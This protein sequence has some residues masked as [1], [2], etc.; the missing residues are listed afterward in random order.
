MSTNS[1]DP[2]HVTY[3]NEFGVS[4][5][6]ALQQP[7]LPPVAE[8]A[9]PPEII[10]RKRSL[11][12]RELVKASQDAR[13][14]ETEIPPELLSKIKV[15]PPVPKR[16]TYHS[17]TIDEPWMRLENARNYSPGASI[18]AEVGA[19]AG[20]TKLAKKHHSHEALNNHDK[21]PVKLTCTAFRDR[22]IEF[23]IEQQNSK[24]ALDEDD[25]ASIMLV[26]L[27]KEFVPDPRTYRILQRLIADEATDLEDECI[28]EAFYDYFGSSVKAVTV[29]DLEQS[30]VNNILRAIPRNLKTSY[31]AQISHLLEEV[32]E[33]FRE[34]GK[35][36][37]VHHIL[38]KPAHL[39]QQQ[40]L[41]TYQKQP[42]FSETL[43]NPS[44]WHK[45]FVEN[46][47]KIERLL[48]I[49]NHAL[50]HLMQT[51][52][53][54]SHLRYVDI[55]EMR[56]QRDAFR[57]S[58]Y[59]SLMLVQAEKCRTKIWHGWLAI[60]LKNFAET[61]IRKRKREVLPQK[62][63]E[64]FF[65][66]AQMLICNQLQAIMVESI[67]D[68]VH[69]F[70][71]YPIA[72]SNSD[73]VYVKGKNLK[74]PR[75]SVRLT[76]TIKAR[77]IE[78]D[79]PFNEIEDAV[80]DGLGFLVSTV[81]TAPRIE[82]AIY[83]HNGEALLAM[84]F[85][86]IQTVL[87]NTHATSV[88]SDG[89]PAFRMSIGDVE[90]IKLYVE[91]SLIEAT[92]SHLKKYVNN[93]FAIAAEY[94]TRYDPYIELFSS[95]I[96]CQVEEFFSTAHS[97]EE[98][99]EQIEKYKSIVNEIL[100]HPRRVELVLIDL[101]TE[102]LHRIFVAR[103]NSLA[104]RFIT[105]ITEQ[106][107][108]HQ[109]QIC[110]RYEA[111]E[112]R[113][114]QIPEGFKEM[115]EQM[116]YM[117]KTLEDEL[118]LLL[119]ELEESRR[120][121]MHIFN[122]SL[123][124]DEHIKLNS[125][126]FTWPAKIIPILEQHN[127]IIGAAREKSEENLRERRTKFEL[128]L[129]EIRVQVDELKEV[130]DL[131]EMPFYVKKVQALA[132]QLQ[133]AQDS[134]AGFNKEEQLF[135][136]PETSYPQRKQIM[137][138]LEPFQALYT[139]AVTFQKSYKKWM[140]G[141]LLEL[142]AEQIE[143]E[144]DSLK[145]DM[146][147]V[148]GALVQDSAP[149][150]IAKAVKE[151]IDE[152]MVNIPLIH[153]LCNPGM[154]DRHW[155]KMSAAAEFEIRPDGS[156]SLRKMLKM[157]LEQFLVPFQ[158][159]SDFASKEYT[160]EK[161]M[162]KMFQE[163]EPLEFILIAYR[164]T[165]THI[166][167][168][169]DE[170]QQLLDDQ[171]VKTQSMRGSP[172]I[173]PFEQ[174]IKEWEHKLLTTQEIIDEWLKVQA[175]WLYLEPIFSSEDIMNQMP[176]ESKKFKM[177][178]YSWRKTMCVVSQDRH[179]LKIT[180]IPN[181]LE[182]LQKNNIML[183]EIL[184]GLNSYLEVK[185]LFFPRFF[186][187]SN[188]EMLEILSE[189]KDPTRVQPHLK[190]CF[191]G[192]ATLEFD[193]KLDIIS[194]YS[195][196]KE[197]LALTKKVSTVDAKGTV[198]KWLR[199]VENAMLSSLHSIIKAAY[200]AY[201]NSPRE[202]WVLEWPGQ[203][204]ICVSQIYWTL[205]V[206][207]AI[208]EG[209]RGIEQHLMQLNR[210][211]NETIKLV[212]GELS[213]MARYTL[214][215]LVVIDVHAR[216][217]IANMAHTEN[218]K[219]TNDFA[220]L[221]QLRYYW[222]NN[223]VMVKM[224]NAQKRYGYEYL[225]NSA[226]LVIT[227]LTDR[228][229]RTLFGALHLNLGGAPEGP[230]GTGKTETTKD[231]AKALAKQCVVFNCSDGL[232]YLAM[233]K[234][235]KGLATSGAWACFDEFNRIDLEVLSVVAQQILTIQRAIALDLKE[236]MFEGSKLALNQQCAVF[237][238]MNPG[239]AGRSEL[240][241]NLKALFRTVAMMVPDYSLIAEI[242]LYSFGFI[243]AR[244]LARKIAAT[245]RLC[246]E[247]LSSQDHYDYGMRAVKSVLTA[248]G[249]LKLKY[250]D[251][252][253]SVLVL[254]SIID[255][256]LPKFLSQD[257][258][259]FKGIATDLF[260]GVC[261]PKSDYVK[262]EDAIQIACQ[263]M[264]LQ[265]VPA[266]V[267]KVFQ[268]YEMMLV[269][270]GY[271]LVGEPFS[272]KTTAYRVLGEAL[273]IIAANEPAGTDE[274][275]SV[276]YKAI[277]PKS[278]TMGQLYGQFDPISHEWTD[279]VLATSFRSYASSTSPDRK[280]VIFDGPVDAIWVENMNTVLDDNKKLC[281]M[282]GEIIQL[283]NT[284]SL[285]FEV[286]DL[287][288]ASPAT[289]SRCG[290]VYLEPERLGWRPLLQSWL[291]SIT[292]LSATIKEYISQ[293]F[294]TF[295]QP[296]LTFVRKDCK[297]L[298][299]TTDIGLVNSLLRLFDSTF[300][301][302]RKRDII[303]ENDQDPLWE[304][305]IQ[306]RFLFCMAWT[307]G[308][309]IDTPSQLK[310]DHMMRQ[311]IYKMQPPLK[312]ELPIEGTIYD[313][314]YQS[315]QKESDSDFSNS[316]KQ[317]QHNKDAWIPWLQTI[318]A[319]H[320]P[321]NSDFN[322]II[323]PTKDTAR[324]NY[325][326]DLMILH[327]IPLLLVGPTGTG[328]SKYI[329][330]KLL[331]GI[332][333]DMFLPLAINFSAR[334]SA[335][336]VQDLVMAK[337][338]KRRK[339]VFGAPV[340]KRYIVFID[341]L[342]MPAKE[343]YGAQPPIELFRQWIDH[344]NWYDRKD[345]SRIELVDIQL[346]AAMGPPGGGRN[347]ITPRF[348]RHFNQVV[349]NSF[350][351]ATM[352]RIFNSILE[353]HFSRFEFV[354][355]IRNISYILVD[356][357]MSVYQ[358][359]VKNLLPTPAKTHYTFNLRDFAKVIQGL[360]LSRPTHFGSDTS[361]L[362]LWTHEVY[363]VYYDRLVADEDRS[364]MFAFVM[365]T[366]NEKFKK[367]PNIVF[368]HVATGDKIDESPTVVDD[369]MR[370]VFFGD[371]V[372]CASPGAETNYIEVEN[373]DTIS[374]ICKAQLAEYNQ[375]K[376]TKLDLVLFRFAIEHVSKIC[377]ILKLPGGNALLVGV[378]GS[379]RQSLTR[380][381]AFISKYQVFQI[382]ISKSYSRVEWRDDLKKILTMTGVENQKTVFLF[383][384]T[385]IREESFIEDVNSLLNAGDV[386]N[387]FAADERQAIVEKLAN[388]A[389]E[390][391]KAADASPMAIYSYFV[392][393]VKKNLH[394]VL[395]MS[396]I[397]DA[398]RA[399]LRQFSSIVN[400]CTIDWFQA[401]PND[402]L[403]AVA[404]QF[405]Q[406][407]NLDT[408]IFDKVIAMC[409]YF[410]QYAIA[411]SQR[412][413]V[414]L[415]R[416]NYVTPTSYLELLNAYKTL[417][418][419]KFQEISMVR[420]RY[421]GGLDKLQFAAEQI[422]RMQVDLKELQPQLL[423]TS[424]ETIEMLAKIEKESVEVEST[425]KTVAS[426]EAIASFKAE[427]SAAMKNECE[428][429]LAEALPLLN[430]ALAAL[431]TLK[432]TDIDLVKSMKNPPDGVKLVME[433]V[434]VMKDIKPEKIPDPSGS[435]RMVL[436]YWKP[437]LKMLGDPQFLNSLKS[438]DKDDIPPHVIKKIRQTFIPNPEFKP[439]KVRNASSAAEGLCSWIGAMEAY[440]RVA[441]IVAPKQEALAKAEAELA[442]TMKGLDEKRALLKEIMDR[443]QSLNNNLQA[444]TEK[445]A[446]LEKEVKS[447]EDQL[448]RAQKLLGGL[449]GE[450]H[451]WTE[452]TKQLDGTL[453]NL[454]G[455]VLIS[456]G[457]AAY[458]GA[459][460][461]L[462]RQECVASWVE[463]LKKEKIPCTDA[464]SLIKV[465][466]D[467]IKIREW[468]IAGLP[469][470]AFSVDNGIIVQNARRWPLM[471][472][473]QGQAN[474]WVK[475]MEKNHKLVIIKL[476]DT[477]FVRNLE[478]AI[479]FGLPV[480]LENL[481]EELDPILD[482][483]L[484]KQTFKSGGATCIRLGD[485]VIEYAES[486]RLY[487]TTKLRNPHYFPET[488]VKVSLLNFMITPE[489]LEDQL[490]GIVV[491]K[492]RPEL[493]EEK[494]QL[495]FQ[496]AENK[497]KLQ[498]I[499]DQ[500]LQILSSAEGNILENETAI[501]VLSSSKVLSVE[502]FDK[503]R[504][505]EETECKI[506][507]TRE[508]YR[509]IAN[510]SA[511]NKS[512]V[513]KRRLKNLESYFTYSLYCNVCRSLFEK[514]KLL[515]SFLLCITILRKYN[516]LDEAEFAHFMT[517]GIGLGGQCIPNPDPS[518]IS[519]KGWTEIGR[520]SDLPA[521]KGLIQEF[522]LS[523][524]KQVIDTNDLLEVKFPGK[525][526]TINDF[527]HL[528]I[529][530][531][532]RPEKIVPSVQEFV[533]AKLGHKFIEPPIFDLAGSYEDSSNHSP[534]IFI[535]SPGV[536]PM[537]QLIKFAEDQGFGGQKCQ[538]IS[539]GQGQGPIAA[540]MIREAQKGG[541]WVVLQNCHLAVS[542][543]STLEKIVDDMTSG[544][545]V[546]RDFRLWLTSY[547]SPKFPSSILQ[548]G[549]KMTNEP[550]KGIKANI[551]KSYLSDP[552]SN[553]K[554]FAA[555]KKP[556]EWEK[557]LFGLCTFHAIVQ[558]RRNFG[559]LGWNI[560]YEFNESDLRISIRQLQMFLDEYAEIPFKAII[561]L[562]GECNYG[563]RV[564]DE[565]D[566]R[567]LTNL[568]TT[569]Y[570]PAIVEDNGYR[571]SPSGVYY[572]PAKGKYDQYLEYV[573][574]L[575]LN[576]SPE[577]F[578]IHDNGDI[579]R[580]LAETRQLFESV[581]QT[582]GNTFG[583][584]QGNGQKSS[585]EIIIEISSDILSRIPAA[586]NLEEAIKRY[587]VDYN[588]SMNTVLVQEMIRFNKLIQV[589]LGSLANVQKAI[590]GLVVNSSELEEVCKSILVGRVPAMWAARSYPSLKPLGG[591]VNDLIARIKFF[592]TWL[593]HGSPVVFWMSGFFFTQS[594]ITAT[595]QNYA[596]KYTI[597]IDELGLDF[598]VM[599]TTTSAVSP[600]DGVYVNG[601]YLEGARWV[602]ERNVLGESFNKVLYDPM[603]MI[604]FKPI[605]IVD[606]K[607]TGTYTLP[608]YKTSARR[609]VLS[610]TGHSTNFVIAI[611]LPTDK[612]E[613]HWIMR[614]LAAILQLDN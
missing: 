427:Q 392:D 466:G 342:N 606:T 71:F 444:L 520:L 562:T 5:K 17:H 403:Q 457:V 534:L 419:Q 49:S 249:N 290:M 88:D 475:N 505:A 213:K 312:L 506:D 560:P 261:L 112:E 559:P 283:S 106:S 9:V 3:S 589:V 532:L 596:R 110:A 537:A 363:R 230:A 598:E 162:S 416:H 526:N 613:K 7:H 27:P 109:Q 325:L 590:K 380:L 120:K 97:F 150:N 241:D 421:A 308:G 135:G 578:G 293:L 460:T 329:S 490:L 255:V 353:W 271:M 372:T 515:F 251:E 542:W 384:D 169:V 229:Y 564:T 491:A 270:H 413:L 310:F 259:L 350:D 547:P 499:E 465:L 507:E 228:C 158:E 47:A 423:K 390:D 503:Q 330:S 315:N 50:C 604:W 8:T 375:V 189:T 540:Q 46:K 4:D 497:K 395:C 346:I 474:K 393:R 55:K 605:R 424:E 483:I 441:K 597:P 212:R 558:E 242:T 327:D 378:G 373:F 451:R 114:L 417:L 118:P 357:T 388:D 59:R 208:L 612:P 514:D 600:V 78:F 309:S 500:I 113:A 219:D 374:E 401:W 30:W 610:T 10:L 77:V 569:F 102:D 322:D 316:T 539:L 473:P 6:E 93:C 35:N 344:G 576:Q 22:L 405:L 364:N 145:R 235:F 355:E 207:K 525:W 504:V 76:F 222:E 285:V 41:D 455:D 563:G 168:S 486:F 611:R 173:K 341:D 481:K 226:R 267:E 360:V 527:Q 148:L 331:N 391:G 415:S 152:F 461:K 87:Q 408:S 307:I 258:A 404:K 268:L 253:E 184:K 489:G 458:L 586:F 177:V 266:F 236:F 232:D 72:L 512:S 349:I 567:T 132:K 15:R 603:P 411:L 160:L 231:L 280:W 412:Y 64:P 370:S 125:K 179:I 263:R 530:R 513:V 575:P 445:K 210:D 574:S 317:L 221:S 584:S 141:N 594:F 454:S 124:N 546:H 248:A 377:R 116:E 533:K 14:N 314:L 154:R 67:N 550:P 66:C 323:I 108:E 361:M 18:A 406:D 432:K 313:Y 156:A 227:P 216:D 1:P 528:L 167:A 126:T 182:E 538:S 38:K 217:V 608:V 517:G 121:L 276:Q 545:S 68:Y 464:F 482:T 493:E 183:E 115:A 53:Y 394:I 211:L 318:P 554:F 244:N 175:T 79:P 32:Q 176:E 485:A 471:I 438:F 143:Q 387:L 302:F 555:C 328:K 382:E 129:E 273:N 180:T 28:V 434:C 435:G 73:A 398:F 243:E 37:A 185:R 573:R 205:A 29:S 366:I 338:D 400:C 146:Y 409:Q 159:I 522:S 51:A 139:T 23:L 521:F 137:A 492:E 194:L 171:I 237:I 144:V 101:I 278:I 225:G 63:S 602:K 12:L 376:K 301:D 385:Q 383:P 501:E 105:K 369:D 299:P 495:I 468:N 478:N 379:G 204:V 300:D 356:S 56:S 252:D 199:D 62:P 288:V 450:K 591:Y 326:M 354:E 436:D 396:P 296:S 164:E 581:I 233:G 265:M 508:S 484:Q 494:V 223:N 2:I 103:A 153:V 61:Y 54:F 209:K 289:V 24:S 39:Q 592:Q 174:Q 568:L 339:G 82:S 107:I 134:V 34:S 389:V 472:D 292:Y 365:S 557:L 335:N 43:S 99:V 92:N 352:F 95:E 140:D 577:I 138:A 281:L 98:H 572:A 151:K 303:E 614:G 186:F 119:L 196:E 181:L 552:I 579:A 319:I 371:F 324:Y 200:L 399:R 453:Y 311:C 470:D 459:F 386:P 583:S 13:V 48:F 418:N 487:M 456:A 282:S 65:R 502:L 191:E 260:P 511:S 429:D 165:G 462:Y 295:V 131:D 142:D 570:C 224:I 198:E 607:T 70:S 549:V 477:D 529:I 130:G 362:R 195:S 275:L 587:P 214:G 449:G 407:T 25:I 247:Q 256:N 297:E 170:A 348:Q 498:E 262:L 420:K 239:Y 166:L 272:G 26:N 84:E 20:G 104:A 33:S 240:P 343:Q 188:D 40:L 75:F 402:A 279:G 496:S 488:S 476:T 551:L 238:T 428:N 337:L 582:Q 89:N 541:T 111:I 336:Q 479:T 69:M 246:S 368:A 469:S 340:G 294:E 585:E 543:L 565:W 359:A 425:R 149:Q 245:Y 422:A 192:V 298:S 100:S 509:P 234:F 519:E 80:L 443:L 218:I 287:S 609:G 91:D 16:Y 157:N 264:N 347:L 193:E 556:A 147:R 274:W 440:D 553:E 19:T 306:C 463:T 571:F 516:D 123:L 136:W 286:M 414:A 367:D 257:I 45:S 74:P 172:Y 334:T 31:P 433:A 215:A 333:R 524:W 426:D 36:S 187:L 446:R 269:R 448:D 437:S 250:P 321:T 117:Q 510:H 518:I 410:H 431:D 42:A 161:N 467:P 60:I 599:P 254:R 305:R 561:Y 351:D 86:S 163:W 345:T 531:A 580:Q 128:E 595:L 447:C 122:Y 178:D 593:E 291:N 220:W 57:I 566:R 94:L 535:L 21:S 83:G 155:T 190:K 332:S 544:A 480:L 397:G 133:A 320:L 452:I 206:E 304:Q 52:S 439:E 11:T 202:K 44:P 96:D 90:Q 203:V 430:A 277:N 588:E 58:S 358:W 127:I 85:P 381:S 442:E 284:M 523:G 601:L 197:R 201:P 81:D 536:D 548:I